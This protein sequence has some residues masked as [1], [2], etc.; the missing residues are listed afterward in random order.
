MASHRPLLL[1]G[2]TNVW[3]IARGVT[4]GLKRVKRNL[5]IITDSELLSIDDGEY[6]DLVN[7]HDLLITV[8]VDATKEKISYFPLDL[9]NSGAYIISQNQNKSDYL[10]YFDVYMVMELPGVFPDLIK[11]MQEWKPNDEGHSQ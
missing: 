2:T 6:A 10:L 3:P 11:M 7:D 1:L 5:Q 4:K 9:K 8:E